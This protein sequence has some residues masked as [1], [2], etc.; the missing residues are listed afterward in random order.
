M[1]R[2]LVL[3]SVLCLVPVSQAFAQPTRADYIAQA[4]PICLSTSQAESNAAAGLLKD[5]A[6]GHDKVAARKLRRA[7]VVFSGGVEQLAALEQPPADAAL[8]GTWIASLR[9]Q[10]PITKRFARALN[11]GQ[12]KRIRKSARQLI[13]AE[14]KTIALVD[15]YGFTLCSQ[16]SA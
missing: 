14:E 13:L 10:V 6:K 16:F 8:L 5:L 4:D 1:K 3:V 11:R 2:C 7:A 15:D 9:A 12:E